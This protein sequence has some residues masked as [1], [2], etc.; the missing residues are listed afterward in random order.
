MAITVRNPALAKDAQALPWMF[1]CDVDG[2]LACSVHST[3]S[4]AE[5]EKSTHPCPM[6][7]FIPLKGKSILERGWDE[8]DG[9]MDQ[10][11]DGNL[12][13]IPRTKAQ[14][15]VR[16][17]AY[18]LSMMS[19][20]HYRSEDDVIRQAIKR[21]KMR[22]G[23]IPFEETF[24]YNFHSLPTEE[25]ALGLRATKKATAAPPIRE[26][27]LPGAQFEVEIKKRKLDDNDR[28]AIKKHMGSGMITAIELGQMYQISEGAI[29]YIADV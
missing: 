1:Q 26:A 17:L 2:C 9:L 27:V 29:K 13:D 11:N 5:E 10:I 20:P 4:A 18:A 28:A 16:G 21:Y 25:K 22:Q 15:R 19:T 8:V 23:T 12:E 7:G 14:A 24:G 3:K 6:K